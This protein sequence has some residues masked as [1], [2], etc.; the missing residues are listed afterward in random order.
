[1]ENKKISYLIIIG[2]L[3]IPTT[4]LFFRDAWIEP[5]SIAFYN[6]TCLN[7]NDFNTPKLT[8]EIFLNLPC[9]QIIW[10]IVQVINIAGIFFALLY[11]IRK[12]GLPA[13]TVWLS[14]LLYFF[15]LFLLALEDDHLT[16]P[17]I[18]ILTYLLFEKRSI[19]RMIGYALAIPILTFF[20]WEGS[21]VVM[22][23][24]LASSIL[25]PL[26]IASVIVA[27]FLEKIHFNPNN[28][29]SELTSG[30]GFI[31]NNVLVWLF[32]LKGFDFSFLKKYQVEFGS[33]FGILLLTFFVPKFGVFLI[34]PLLPLAGLS[35]SSKKATFGLLCLAG[36]FGF[37]V[38]ST[39]LLV[40][41]EPLDPMWDLVEEGVALQDSGALVYN[42]WWVGR[43]FAYKGGVPTEEGG[44]KGIPDFPPD[45]EYYW[46]GLPFD[47]CETIRSYNFAHL[48][49]C[50][51]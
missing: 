2:L 49:K 14:G 20:Y 9:D 33:L 10:K 41:H 18:I 13:K 50:S 6:R 31:A 40:T 47:S 15:P 26:G 16:F 22:S 23:I 51:P 44:Y 30:L 36:F 39:N 27:F 12:Y 1:M 35:F 28:S 21:F 34:I 42:E 43:W 37:L 17:I 3:L 46:L 45:S 7:G 38:I 19:K 25:S 29:S 4:L 11:G 8:K 32:L 48:Q 24:F 5:D